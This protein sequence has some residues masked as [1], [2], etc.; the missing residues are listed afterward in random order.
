MIWNIL[1]LLS[2][3]GAVT[4]KLAVTA[5]VTEIESLFICYFMATPP[6][7]VLLSLTW[8]LLSCTTLN[9]Q[10]EDLI[11]HPL[12]YSLSRSLTD[13]WHWTEHQKLPNF[14]STLLFHLTAC[15]D[16]WLI[17]CCSLCRYISLSE[18]AWIVAG[19]FGLFLSLS[20]FMNVPERV[21]G[22]DSSSKWDTCSPGDVVP[23][24]SI[25]VTIQS[26]LYVNLISGLNQNHWLFK[27][28][29]II[30]PNFRR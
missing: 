2:I 26:K 28:L 20:S 29:V 17:H 5:F 16:C 9:R 10:L 23:L 4:V 6:V 7:T 18:S 11:T 25:P 15:T 13:K 22:F 24:W 3:Y 30:T 12:T 8:A 27:I 19:D 14:H 1:Y 21:V